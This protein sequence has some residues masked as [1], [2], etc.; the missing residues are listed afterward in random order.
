[1]A[2]Q[3]LSSSALRFSGSL[4]LSVSGAARV[5]SGLMEDLVEEEARE[6]ERKKDHSAGK[7]DR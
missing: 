5:T 2:R 1:M 3:D 4:D 7:I 6:K